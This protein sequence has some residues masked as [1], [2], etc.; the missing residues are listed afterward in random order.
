MTA[1]GGVRRA[2]LEEFVADV[3]EGP[4]LDRI[5]H[6]LLVQAMAA[7]LTYYIINILPVRV[8]H[9]PVQVHHELEAPQVTVQPEA[10]ELRG[11]HGA[12]PVGT[13]LLVERWVG[14][15]VKR[16]RQ[17]STLEKHTSLEKTC[18]EKL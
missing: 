10:P 13:I 3:H 1:G 7:Q 5:R 18:L 11:Q 9:T 6:G 17:Q 15:K 4:G 14:P 12:L 16:R 8:Q 2:H